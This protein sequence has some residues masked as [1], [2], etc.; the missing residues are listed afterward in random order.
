MKL[1]WSARSMH[2]KQK[3]AIAWDTVGG[4]DHNQRIWEFLS[5]FQIDGSAASNKP[6]AL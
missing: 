2:R 4:R 6:Y 5:Q 1:A 3:L